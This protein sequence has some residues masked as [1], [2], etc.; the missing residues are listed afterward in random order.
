MENRG[1]SCRQPQQETLLEDQLSRKP[2]FHNS[3]WGLNV[4]WM[5]YMG[6]SHHL[7][8]SRQ[9]G[10]CCLSQLKC[11][12][13]APRLSINQVFFGGFESPQPFHLL[14]WICENCDHSLVDSREDLY[15]LRLVPYT[16]S[17]FRT[18]QT[19]DMEVSAMPNISN[20]SRRESTSSSSSGEE[21]LSDLILKQSCKSVVFDNR[22]FFPEGSIEPLITKKSVIDELAIRKETLQE[23]STEEFLDFVLTRGRRLLAILINIGLTGEKLAVATRQFMEIGFGDASLP[24]TNDNVHN[25]PFFGKKTDRQLRWDSRLKREFRF[26]QFEYLAPIFSKDKLDMELDAQHIFPFVARHGDRKV[27]GFGE[28]Y[29]VD[30][31]P[32]HHKT[33]ILTVR[34]NSVLI[35]PVVTHKMAYNDKVRQKTFKHCCQA[36]NGN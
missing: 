26:K 7:A 33:P 5:K 15:P 1:S 31:H 9:L 16:T 22:E 2:H 4:V 11:A 8:C 10:A 32:A 25:V 14:P 35:N 13:L 24:I 34:S 28:V 36:H 6:A 18:R 20:E 19:A 21:C 12:T 3:F 29:Q 17:T 30:P 23:K 27:G